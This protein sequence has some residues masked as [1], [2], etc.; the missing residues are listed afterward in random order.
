MFGETEMF[1]E[2]AIGNEGQ[3]MKGHMIMQKLWNFER[4]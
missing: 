1:G 3:G 2:R 4:R